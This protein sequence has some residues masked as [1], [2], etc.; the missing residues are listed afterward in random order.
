MASNA[1]DTVISMAV[2]QIDR[3]ILRIL[4]SKGR[5]TQRELGREVGLSPNAAG[6]RVQRLIDGGII[7]GFSAQLD[8][9][10]LGRPIEASIDV[11]LADDRS[12]DPLLDLVRADDRI[13]ECFHLTGPLDF[14]IRARVGS[15]EDLNDLLTRMRTEG[16]VRQ[17][18]SRLILEQVST[19]M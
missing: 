6:A 15:A 5:M 16:G 14:R 19:T 8:H 12:R 2:D 13:V 4:Q 17:T 10:A 11:W 3:D 18:D 9:A 1:T 7:R